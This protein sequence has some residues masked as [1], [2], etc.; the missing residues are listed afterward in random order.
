MQIAYSR[1]TL[2]DNPQLTDYVRVAKRYLCDKTNTLWLDSKWERYT[3]EDLLVEWF[4]YILRDNEEQK[5]RFEV[6]HGV[7][8]SG[9]EDFDSWA[10]AQIQENKETLDA[11]KAELEDNITF[12][13]EDA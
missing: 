2:P 11:K 8:V 1:V 12:K 4:T 6:D 13:P 7:E 5:T 10:N 9:V 3:D